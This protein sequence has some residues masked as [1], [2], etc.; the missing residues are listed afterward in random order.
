MTVYHENQQN[1]KL[2]VGYFIDWRR[3][4]V[5]AG[6]IVNQL[7]EGVEWDCVTDQVEENVEESANIQKVELGKPLESESVEFLVGLVVKR[8]L[9]VEIELGCILGWL[10]VHTAKSDAKNNDWQ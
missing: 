3:E 10:R 6:V 1:K 4:K 2:G 7:I 5:C 8:L 9:I